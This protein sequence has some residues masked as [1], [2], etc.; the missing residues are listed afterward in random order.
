[1]HVYAHVN[2]SQQTSNGRSTAVGIHMAER[3]KRRSKLQNLV[4]HPETIVGDPE[5]IVHMDWS[6]EWSEV[7]RRV[8]LAT[9]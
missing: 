7:R 1:M 9:W 2:S 3:A 6:G 5:S 8:K 4:T